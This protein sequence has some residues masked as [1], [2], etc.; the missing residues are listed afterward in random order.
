[1]TVEELIKKLQKENPKAKVIVTS[2]NF[3][4][5]HANIEL[6]SVWSSKTGREEIRTFRDAFDGD[7]YDT[8]VWFTI[9][10][11]KPIVQLG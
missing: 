11:K 9:D 4:L 2:S 8:K 1:M 3:E 6:T 7:T 10:G 5:N